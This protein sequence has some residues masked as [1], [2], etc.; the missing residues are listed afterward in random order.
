MPGDPDSSSQPFPVTR[1]SAVVAAGSA[2]AQVR[3]AAFAVLAEAYWRPAY[4]HVRLRR[5]KRA[6]DAADLVQGF[7]AAALEKGWF[8]T[9]DA[10]KARFRTFLR[11]CLDGFVSNQDKAAARLK[12]GGGKEPLSFDFAAEEGELEHLEPA[13][14]DAVERACDAAWTRGIFATALRRLQEESQGRGRDVAFQLFQRYDVEPPPGACLTY[15]DLANEFGIKNTDVVNRLAV[16]RREFRRHVLEAL[17]E[18]TSSDAEFRDEARIVL[19][20]SDPP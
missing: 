10:R 7:F 20:L 15:D 1:A 9:F 4:A 3:H 5:R 11:T 16:M 2:D 12:R 18:A 19:G 14:D 8:A 6:E 17:R 13:S